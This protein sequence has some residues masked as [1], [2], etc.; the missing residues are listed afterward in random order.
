MTPVSNRDIVSAQNMGR[1]SPPPYFLVPTAL[2]RE[3]GKQ[4]DISRLVI[5][6]LQLTSKPYK[7]MELKSLLNNFFSFYCLF[8]YLVIHIV[9]FFG[10]KIWCNLPMTLVLNF[11]DKRFLV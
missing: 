11:K 10:A 6:F 4:C 2:N 9:D 8:I 5:K 1:V 3:E 7:W